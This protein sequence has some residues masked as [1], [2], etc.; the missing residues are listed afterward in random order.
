VAELA[1]EGLGDPLQDG[2]AGEVAIR[3]VDVAQQV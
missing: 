3:V 1:A 2:I